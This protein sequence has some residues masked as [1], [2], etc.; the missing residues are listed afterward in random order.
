MMQMSD[1]GAL[2]DFAEKY[3]YIVTIL[4]FSNQT[5]KIFIDKSG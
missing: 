5:Y 2:R 1:R 4:Q 3:F